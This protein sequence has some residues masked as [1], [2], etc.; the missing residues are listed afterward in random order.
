MSFGQKI[1]EKYGYKQGTGN[2]IKINV[3]SNQKLYYLLKFSGLGKNND[4]IIQPIKPSFKFDNTGLGDGGPV[5]NDHWWERT[6]NDASNNLNVNSS[7]KVT[8]TQIDKEGVEI[9]NKS[10]SMKK[11]KE[12]NNTLQY[13]SF[14]KTATLLANVGEEQ[15]IQGHVK[16]EDIE[17]Q[18]IKVLTDDE[19]LK[20]CDFRTA[21]KGIKIL[22]RLSCCNNNK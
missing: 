22:S 6:F 15:E 11:L 2:F 10:Y 1:L 7:G 3:K 20:A 12:S 8:I 21:H 5:K 18:P 17:I 4:G 16:T 9:T 19:L 13:G 14:L